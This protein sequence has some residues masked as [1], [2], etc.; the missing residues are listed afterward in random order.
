MWVRWCSGSASPVEDCDTPCGRG[1]ARVGDAIGMPEA[2]SE[3]WLW[4]SMTVVM[5][6]CDHLCAGAPGVA[7][8]YGL[9]GQRV[10]LRYGGRST[11]FPNQPTW[12]STANLARR[13]VSD[14]G[15]VAP[16][17]S[18]AAR[19]PCRL[20]PS[21]RP[22]VPDRRV[23]GVI[24]TQV[25]TQAADVSEL[26]QRGEHTSGVVLTQRGVTQPPS[27]LIP[28]QQLQ[29]IAAG[30]CIRSGLI[31]AD[32]VSKHAGLREKRPNIG[33]NPPLGEW[34]WCGRYPA[35]VVAARSL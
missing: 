33:I 27:T 17:S 6:K 23:P 7:A 14:A 21:P 26:P 31:G 4:H 11:V 28:S 12:A 13:D 18:P 20:Q 3:R 30:R 2:A 19:P 8:N 24:A 32:R 25:R 9:V 29:L 35:V 5:Q 22:P 34:E 10:R 16:R 15:G 1:C